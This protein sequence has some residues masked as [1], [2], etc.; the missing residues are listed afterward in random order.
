MNVHLCGLY[1]Q[2]KCQYISFRGIN[3]RSHIARRH[4]NEESVQVVKVVSYPGCKIKTPVQ[5]SL[6]TY[7]ELK[8]KKPELAERVLKTYYEEKRRKCKIRVC[9]LYLNDK[10]K[11]I[12][13]ETS[14]IRQHMQSRHPCQSSQT[15]YK[16]VQYPYK[17]HNC[18]AL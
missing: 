13:G 17:D 15:I 8:E 18:D 12:T 1:L 2:G 7:E 3:V 11:Y 4:Q 14:H 9:S 6:M 16:I 5:Y 10:C